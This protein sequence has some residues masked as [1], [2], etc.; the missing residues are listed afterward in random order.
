MCILYLR[1]SSQSKEALQ[2]AEVPFRHALVDQ[3][4]VLRLVSSRNGTSTGRS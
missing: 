2:S 3:R 1:R 4:Q